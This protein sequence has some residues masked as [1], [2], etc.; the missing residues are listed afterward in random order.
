MNEIASAS[1][2]LISQRLTP[3][4]VP[5]MRR[6]LDK[7]ENIA[8]LVRNLGINNSAHEN[9]TQTMTLLVS[10]NGMLARPKAE[11]PYNIG[12]NNHDQ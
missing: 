1:K 12:R 4:D 6:D 2:Q 11:L 8:W 10:L 3:M 5:A 9:Y 7:P